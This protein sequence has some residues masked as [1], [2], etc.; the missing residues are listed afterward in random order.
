MVFLPIRAGMILWQVL[1][2]DL[3]GFSHVT[4]VFHNISRLST[5]LE[6]LDLDFGNWH[7]G[8]GLKLPS[9]APLPSGP[10]K[11]EWCSASGRCVVNRDSFSRSQVSIC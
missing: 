8:K 1:D 11:K 10:V 7:L 4:C 5:L 6:G 3:Y 2:Q 9:N